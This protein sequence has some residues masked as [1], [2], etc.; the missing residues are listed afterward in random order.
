M[1][2]FDIS[3]G[4]LKAQAA[5]IQVT[6]NN[7]ANASTVGFKSRES[8][9]VD[10][11]F[12]AVQARTPQASSFTRLFMMPGVL[13]CAGG[14]GCDDVDWAAT[15]RRWVEQGDAPSRIVARKRRD[16][17]VVRTHALCAYPKTARYNGTGSTGDAAAYSCR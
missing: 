13:H 16:T 4:G 7:V 17:T 1:S 3:S 14:S 6:S 11:Y 8:L 2:S 5:A 15:I 12:K 9:F 10:Q